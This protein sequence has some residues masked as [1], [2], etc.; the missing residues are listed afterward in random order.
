MS[1]ACHKASAS[2]PRRARPSKHP[3]A[4]SGVHVGF[5]SALPPSQGRLPITAEAASPSL[6]TDLET[7]RR[8]ADD[9]RLNEAAAICEAHLRE[10]RVSAQAYY[11]LGLVRDARGEVGAIDCYLK[12]LYLEPNHYESLLQMAL[13]LQKNG[14]TA[15]ASAFKSRAQRL[16]LRA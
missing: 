15:R 7:A 13:L 12:A 5:G 1:F 14:D 6:T 4:A 11:L 10:S 8:L 9:G 2:R 16:K 3:A